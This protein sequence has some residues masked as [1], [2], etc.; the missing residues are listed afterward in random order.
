MEKFLAYCNSRKNIYAYGDGV[1]GRI[2]RIFLNEHDIDLEGFIVSNV[3]NEERVL[4]VPVYTFSAL[5]NNQDSAIL[6]CMRQEYRNDAIREVE[7]LGF[8][9]FFVVDDN[10]TNIIEKE[11][12][13]NRQYPEND[14]HCT[15]ALMYHR[16][17]DSKNNPYKL[18][19]S[20][21]RFEEQICYLKDHFNIVN[22]IEDSNEK[23][24]IIIT[25][26]DGYKD[27]YSNAYPILKKYNVPA[28]VFV[29]TGG[30]NRDFSFWWDELYRL[31]ME[32]DLLSQLT[33]NGEI[34]DVD[35]FDSREDLLYSVHK[36]LIKLPHKVRKQQLIDLRKQITNVDE[37][38]SRIMN[39]TQIHEVAKEGLVRIGAHTVNHI[40]CNREDYD[41]Q[42]QEIKD[43]KSILE[44]ITESGINTFA[45]PNGG[46]NETT[47]NILSKLGFSEAY[48]TDEGKI[49]EST[50][51]LMIPRLMM[52]NWSYG[53]MSRVMQKFL[54]VF[55]EKRL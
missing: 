35:C 9:S 27:F 55:K 24:S 36:E 48:T 33:V 19:V 52:L 51:R 22:K 14:T 50:D 11:C 42:L 6:I 53:D 47:V 17:Y 15:L 4:G 39:S 49:G 54:Q 8:E 20:P 16:V 25:F 34:F 18:C 7:D 30:I 21:N 10:L 38:Y 40:V 26:D 46:Y 31:I 44:T 32:G 13:Y 2:V 23:L 43:S 5:C 1:I 41:T 3:S 29:T 45:Y 37:T 28:T 12:K